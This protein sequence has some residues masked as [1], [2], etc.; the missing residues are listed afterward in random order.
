MVISWQTYLLIVLTFL[1]SIVF[2]IAP[3]SA[4]IICFE[5]LITAKYYFLYFQFLLNDLDI[6][7]FQLLA[8]IEF[9]VLFKVGWA[10]FPRA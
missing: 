3:S 5:E 6:P 9:V 1:S 2:L 4:F 7:L 8:L 10:F